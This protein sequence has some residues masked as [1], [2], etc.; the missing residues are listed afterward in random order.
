MLY[1]PDGDLLSIVSEAHEVQADVSDPQAVVEEVLVALHTNTK[2]QA[3]LSSVSEFI[4]LR[5]YRM[6]GDL[7]TLDYD[8]RYPDMDPVTEVLYRASMVQT[9]T[10]IE[11]VDSVLFL[12]SGTSLMKDETTPVGV[13]HAD[14]FVISQLP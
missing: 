5:E 8:V 10:G 12:V 7:L 13:M 3:A 6:E 2:R 1:Y 11:G 14:S 9:L 4:V